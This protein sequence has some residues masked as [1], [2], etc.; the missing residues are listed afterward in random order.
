MKPGAAEITDNLLA[1]KEYYFKKKYLRRI[2]DRIN[3]WC[4]IAALQDGGKCREI[5]LPMWRNW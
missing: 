1:A 5:R 2:L 3:D 4:N